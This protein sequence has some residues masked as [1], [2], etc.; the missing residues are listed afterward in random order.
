MV[1]IE[2]MLKKDLDMWKNLMQNINLSGP[3]ILRQ[4]AP[5]MMYT[6]APLCGLGGCICDQSEEIWVWFDVESTS[7][8]IMW[9]GRSFIP[10]TE[11]PKGCTTI[12]EATSIYV[13]VYLWAKK[14]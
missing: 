9:L 2:F 12:L 6:D 10:K 7:G 8:E 5:I 3:I 13:R 1:K 11:D 4:A 14:Y